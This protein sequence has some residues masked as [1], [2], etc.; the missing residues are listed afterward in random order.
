MLKILLK[1]DVTIPKLG[2]IYIVS[3]HFASRANIVALLKRPVA[4][5]GFYSPKQTTTTF[6]GAFASVQ[7]D[8]RMTG[9]IASSPSAKTLGWQA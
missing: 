4:A 8:A 6:F 7:T 9:M 5:G 1:Q 2:Y 3:I